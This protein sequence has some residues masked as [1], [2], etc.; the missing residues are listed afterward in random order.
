[1]IVGMIAMVAGVFVGGAA[2]W[3]LALLNLL[4]WRRRWRLMGPLVAAVLVAGLAPGA[5]LLA[6]RQETAQRNAAAIEQFYEW[7]GERPVELEDVAYYPD[8]YVFGFTNDAQ[9][10]IAIKLG[11]AFVD[12]VV[13]EGDDPSAEE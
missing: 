12:V 9:D 13:S 11:D 8:T 4:R 6:A 10:H 1:M 2:A 3:T 7:A 5:V